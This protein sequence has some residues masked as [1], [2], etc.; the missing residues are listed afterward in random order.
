M[1]SPLRLALVIAVLMEICYASFY[2]FRDGPDQVL[3]QIGVGLAVYILLAI[4]LRQTRR[5]QNPEEINNRVVLFIIATGVIFRLTLVPHAVVG[6][7]D[8]YRY[9]WDGKVTAS[10][11]NPYSYLPT[12]PHLE[13]LATADL[14]RKVNHPELH[15][16]Y[17]ATAQAFFAGSSFLFGDSTAGMKSLLVLLDSATVIALYLLLKRRGSGGMPVVVYAWSPLPVLYFGLDGHVDALGITLFVIALFFLLTDRTVR[18]VVAIGLSALV[19]FAP[20]VVVPLLMKHFRGV[21]RWIHIT[22]PLLITAIGSLWFL[23]P[24]GGG[25]ESLKTF[26]ERWEFNGSMFSLVYFLSGSNE[27]AHLVSVFLIVGYI[28][29]LTFVNRPLLEKIFWAFYGVLLLSPVVHPWYLTW[30]AALLV[31][32]WSLSAFVFLGLSIVANVVV[33]QYQST[34]LWVDNPVLLLIEYLPVFILLVREILKGDFL[35]REEVVRGV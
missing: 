28:A 1:R 20:L 14:P 31:L 22:I 34:G 35:R 18:G 10:G 29:F 16:V 4:Y 25:I 21:R 7:D 17:P 19:K 2:L 12:D 15:S 13:G 26:G 5:M 11:I 30:L 33:Y 6:S 27:A 32:R 23:V 24:T 8:I 3:V 9:L